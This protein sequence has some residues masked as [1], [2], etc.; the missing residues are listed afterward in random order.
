[1]AIR[2]PTAHIVLGWGLLAAS[3]RQILAPAADAA[4]TAPSPTASHPFSAEANLPLPKR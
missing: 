2:H 1:L 4:R 3:A